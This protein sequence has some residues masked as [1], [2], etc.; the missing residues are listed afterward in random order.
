M[1][2]RYNHLTK[3]IPNN[4]LTRWLIRW[5]N[6]RMDR[7]GS[8]FRLV[9]RYRKPVRGADYGPWGD[10]GK[11]EARRISLYLVVRGAE[12]RAVEQR[13]TALKLRQRLKGQAN[14]SR[15]LRSR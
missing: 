15:V 11:N 1:R 14:D 2:K 5:I 7:D 10:L 12:K 4:R 13:A 9:V 3:S 6:R 8:K